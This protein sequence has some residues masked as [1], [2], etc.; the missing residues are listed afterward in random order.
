MS[1]RHGKAKGSREFKLVRSK[2]PEP[3]ALPGELGT[4]S[5]QP[6]SPEEGPERGRGGSWRAAEVTAIRLEQD[7]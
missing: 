7:L 3:P 4:T 2:S 5:G 6:L 1:G